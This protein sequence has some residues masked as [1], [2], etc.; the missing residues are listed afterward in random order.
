MLA[1]T[2][3]V[4]GQAPFVEVGDPTAVAASDD[5]IVVA[6]DLGPAYWNGRAVW[7]RSDRS[8]GWYP[9]G[10][11]SGDLRCLR[12]LTSRWAVN[13]I[14]L[15]PSGRL[16]AIGTGS[17]DGGY[18]FEGELLL[19]DVEHGTT[20]SVL[21]T[22]RCVDD[23]E[24]TDEQSLRVTLAPP[25]DE[26]V[27]W[28]DITDE[29][30]TFRSDDWLSPT[31]NRFAVGNH[32]VAGAPRPVRD[33]DVLRR[34]LSDL[35]AA[36]GLV[37]ELRRHAWAICRAGD[38]GITLGRESHIEHWT[39]DGATVPGWRIDVEGTC[40][41]LFP[42][43]DGRVVAT[44]WRTPDEP[45]VPRSTVALIIDV[46]TGDHHELVRPGHAAL[47]VARHDGDFLVRD[48]RHGQRAGGPAAV[49]SPTGERLGEVALSAYDLF[50]HYFDIRGAQDFLVLVGEAPTAHRDKSV[51][52]VRRA[53]PTDWNVRRMFPLAWEPGRQLFGGPGVLVDDT[54]GRSIIHAGAVHD[55]RGLLPGNAFL[56]RR[57]YPDGLLQWHAPLDNQ[58]TAVDSLDD[59]VVAVTNLGEILVVDTGTGA[60]LGSDTL[61]AGGHRV[62]PL[63]LALA[64]PNSAW[65]GTLDGRVVEVRIDL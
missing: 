27:D 7:D 21:D 37:W 55:G 19:H 25:T 58:V 35:A 42:T 32:Q 31:G 34:A 17:Y 41:Q 2:V 65:V 22:L 9:V 43:Y 48:T 47:L 46:A 51:A 39:S 59:R 14:A 24:W 12:V 44:V 18:T 38:G 20:T 45:S 16:V 50:N 64:S 28:R 40:T 54:A 11:Y 56:A 33:L 1:D 61:T 8:I 62:I 3:R 6:G 26:D 57:R 52:S 30:L 63:S 4:F 23:L 60:I 13:C 53:G 5:L 29:R 15:H 10:L 36:H 49:V